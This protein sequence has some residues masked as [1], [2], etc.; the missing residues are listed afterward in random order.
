MSD[1]R[2]IVHNEEVDVS[3][4][5]VRTSQPEPER[6][7]RGDDTESDLIPSIRSLFGSLPS[8]CEFEVSDNALVD[9]F[10]E[11]NLN[12]HYEMIHYHRRTLM[13]VINKESAVTDGLLHTNSVTWMCQPRIHVIRCQKWSFALLHKLLIQHL[14]A[15]RILTLLIC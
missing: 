1:L 5:V 15:E 14:F 8:A 3:A 6:T 2:N 10:T 4:N 9:R 7:N 13:Q 11:F 12:Y